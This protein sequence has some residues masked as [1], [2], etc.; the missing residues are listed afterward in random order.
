RIRDA[1]AQSPEQVRAFLTR[2]DEAIETLRRT[3][4]D[5]LERE[6]RLRRLSTPEEDRRLQRE[7]F[8]LEERIRAESDPVTRQ[9]LQAALA[10]LDHQREQRGAILRSAN[11]LDAELTRLLYTLEGLHAQLL[12]VQS[13]SA[14]AQAAEGVRWSIESLRN[15]MDALAEALE[16]V[17]D[18][19]PRAPASPVRQPDAS[20]HSPPPR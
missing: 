16:E 12:R 13:A 18:V 3:G 17:A 10:A 5:L 6:R 15:E 11:R 20:G 9:R 19:A 2:P 4:V 7:R 1:L 8:E 14:P